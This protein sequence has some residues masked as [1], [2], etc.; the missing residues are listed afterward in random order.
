ML[1][2]ETQADLRLAEIPPARKAGVSVSESEL[3]CFEDIASVHLFAWLNDVPLVLVVGTVIA[4]VL[5]QRLS[6]S[7][8]LVVFQILF[9]HLSVS[10]EIL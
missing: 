10:L 7:D 2:G 6:L 1:I 3:W 5:D 9:V 8:S 4:T